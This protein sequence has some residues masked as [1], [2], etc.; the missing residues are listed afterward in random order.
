MTKN[1]RKREVGSWREVWPG[2]WEVRVSCGYRI[3]GKR[4]TECRY[5]KGTEDDA[6]TAARDIAH[7]L[8]RSIN[9]GRGI[10]LS[11]LW[12][13]YLRDKGRRLANKTVSSYQ[14]MMGKT[15]L[16]LLGDRDVSRI[17]RQ[18]VQD[19]M[20]AACSRDMARRLRVVISSVFSWG[21]SVGVLDE[22]VARGEG[23]ELPGDTGSE[24]DDEDIWDDDPFAAIEGDRDVWDARTVME[25][26]PL[27][28]D[29]PLE[30][31]WLAMV[32]AGLRIEEALALRKMDVRRIEIG[33]RKVTQVAVHHARTELDDRKRSKTRGS[34]R[35]AVVMEPFGSRLWEIASALPTKK[36]EVCPVSASNQ[37]KR[38]RSYFN[39]PKTH[40]RMAE[41][42]KV[43][44]RLRG[45]PYIPL[46]RMRATHSTLMQEAGVLDSV[47]AAAH[48]HST[49]VAYS[50]YQ[51]ADTTVAALRTEEYISGV[52]GDSHDG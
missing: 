44:G 15:W 11:R 12:D 32:G 31:A 38:W 20:L 35:I 9:I 34:V 37:N 6:R 28:R 26:L 16:P 21:V 36:S 39:E 46:S 1:T 5:I 4:R 24:W 45:L 25:A 2:T 27:M 22:N 42:R 41:S 52:G 49:K 40:K 33:D 30:P 43:S 13:E 47:N 23:F 10:T 48:G 14:W 8:G 17:T 7:E 3:D 50:N 29:L 51:R 18:D 19:V